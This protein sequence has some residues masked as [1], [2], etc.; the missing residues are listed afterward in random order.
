MGLVWL[1]RALPV[2]LLGACIAVPANSAEDPYRAFRAL[3]ERA[4]G[5]D[6]DAMV[7]IGV[8]YEH[9]EGL[10]RDYEMALRLY[11]TAARKGHGGAAFNIGWMYAKG[12]G[13]KKSDD[14]AAAWFR[15]AAARDHG[16]ALRTLKLI[17]GADD[18]RPACPYGPPAAQMAIGKI[19]APAAV[20]ALVERLAPRHNL[21]PNLVL[22]VIRIES[23][24]QPNAVSRANAQGL[25]Q[26]IP[27]TAKRFGVEDS[28]DPEDNVQGGMAY[29]RWLLDRYDGD[30]ELA[31]AGYNAGEKAVDKHNGVP[32]YAE[33]RD[34]LRKFGE[35]GVLKPKKKAAQ[36]QPAETKKYATRSLD[37]SSVPRFD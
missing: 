21:D 8:A 10:P 2:F 22:A 6:L 16:G 9:A 32:P 29:L 4:L 37:L 20:R 27:A 17:R 35:I 23:A 11:C 1:Q 28:F 33:T 19:M 5:G 18:A 31:L 13:V 3:E 26:L 34:Y 14:Q 30:L 15:L 12:W 7:K 24:F 25:M 36:K